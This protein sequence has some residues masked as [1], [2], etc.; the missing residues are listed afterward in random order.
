MEP[1][2]GIEPMLTEYESVVF[3]LY[4]GGGAAG[5]N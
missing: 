5:E 3:P 2:T 1:L 4:D